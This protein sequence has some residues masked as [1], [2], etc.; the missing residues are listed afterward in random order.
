MIMA[1]T[2]LL[3]MKGRPEQPAARA[4]RKEKG[5][6]RT[7][8]QWEGCTHGQAQ[9]SAPGQRTSLANAC[10]AINGL[11]WVLILAGAVRLVP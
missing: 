3:H 6:E 10:L 4:G 2:R 5:V 7:V 11:S 1:S 8:S 9:Y